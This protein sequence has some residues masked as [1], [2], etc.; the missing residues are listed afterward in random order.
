MTPDHTRRFVRYPTTADDEGRPL[1]V[2]N[3]HDTVLN[4]N[5]ALSYKTMTVCVSDV[6]TTEVSV[7]GEGYGLAYGPVWVPLF[8]NGRSLTFHAFLKME[9]GSPGSPGATVRVTTWASKPRGATT[10][11]M[12]YDGVTNSGT[13]TSTSD[14]YEWKTSSVA[15]IP[16]PESPDGPPGCWLTVEVA[17]HRTVLGAEWMGYMKAITVYE[18]GI[19]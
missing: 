5:N 7:D 1:S 9:T 8:G 10:A 17:G 11:G 19:T 12:V 4:L 18:Q 14:A 15:T 3:F 16:V 13:V 2:H 6:L